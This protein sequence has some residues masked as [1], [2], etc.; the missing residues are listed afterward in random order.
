[1]IFHELYSV[2]YQAVT[3]ILTRVQEGET[4]REELEQIVAQ[5]AFGESSL[6]ILPS[7]QKGKWQLL[8]PQGQTPLVHRPTIPM[9]LLQKQWLKALTLDPRIRLFGVEFPGLD[10]IEPLFTPEDFVI[11]DR[12]GDGDPYEDE[13]YIARFSLILQALREKRPLQLQT[14]NRKGKLFWI[15]GYAQRLEYSEKD[16]K[17]RLLLTD[18]RNDTII[19]LG[20]ITECRLLPPGSLPP[21]REH[22]KEP[23][24]LTL[25]I[26]DER[27][28]LERCL[29][30]F[31]H[32]KKRVEQ[33]DRLCYEL[34]LFYDREDETELLIRILSFGPFVEVLEPPALRE[35]IIARLKAQK[36]C[37]L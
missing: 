25:R 17:F 15:R 34:H 14:R 26:R 21:H 10:G 35:Q 22:R 13:G 12:Y 27:N 9:T 11:Y 28:A 31:A 1:M 6:T 3:K 37:G 23:L 30:H 32:F 16:D 19:N 7:L 36:S 20:R 4:S 2:Y 8:T 5:T 18:R 33:T 29:L 24:E